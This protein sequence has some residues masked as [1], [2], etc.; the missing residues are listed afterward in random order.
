MRALVSVFGVAISTVT[1][2]DASDTT[3][4]KRFGNHATRFAPAT[5]SRS[6]S[7]PSSRATASKS[8]WSTTEIQK[9][10]RVSSG[11]TIAQT[12]LPL[13]GSSQRIGNLS[14]SL[15]SFVP[16]C[17]VGEQPAIMAAS[18]CNGVGGGSGADVARL[19]DG[20]IISLHEARSRTVMAIAIRMDEFYRYNRY[21]I[22]RSLNAVSS[23]VQSAA[24]PF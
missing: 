4:V 9:Y 13:F 10:G 11:G 15:A 5:A 23:A 1:T 16:K 6:S 19:G 17:E 12:M 2:R 8:A 22:R 14:M 24:V 3:S 20:T 7:A 18:T 21:F